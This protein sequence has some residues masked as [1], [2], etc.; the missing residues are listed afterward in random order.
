MQFASADFECGEYYATIIIGIKEVIFNK[1]LNQKG[2]RSL[3]Q[4]CDAFYILAWLGSQAWATQFFQKVLRLILEF[5]IS[6]SH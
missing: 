2:F 6:L 4:L 5:S 1:S 3:S